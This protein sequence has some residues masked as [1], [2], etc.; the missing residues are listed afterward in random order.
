LPFRVYNIWAQQRLRNHS[1][2]LDAVVQECAAHGIT[3]QHNKPLNA[4][5]N[6]GQADDIERRR[7]A[8]TRHHAQQ[9]Q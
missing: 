2:S 6:A 3:A 8:L 9:Q 1:P 7:R 4:D 5:Y